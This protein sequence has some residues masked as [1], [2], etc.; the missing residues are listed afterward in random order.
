MPAPRWKGERVSR[1]LP[2]LEQVAR[3]YF[4][5]RFEKSFRK[6]GPDSK[7]GKEIWAASRRDIMRR[8]ADCYKS[9]E[10]L[11]SDAP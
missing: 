10:A 6:I 5:R 1:N 4:E 11:V 7:A 2:T 8:F 3:H 9:I